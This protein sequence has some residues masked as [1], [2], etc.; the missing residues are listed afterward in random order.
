MGHLAMEQTE[1]LILAEHKLQFYWTLMIRN[2]LIFIK[3]FRYEFE[4]RVNVFETLTDEGCATEPM[5]S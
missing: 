1:N 3:A 4:T 2:H 5:A